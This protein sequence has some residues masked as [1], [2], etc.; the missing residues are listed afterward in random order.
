MTT[1]AEQDYA[2]AV[3]NPLQTRQEFIDAYTSG[4][5]LFHESLNERGRYAIPCRCGM[6]GC[7]GWQFVHPD[8]MERWLTRLFTFVKEYPYVPW[9]DIVTQ[10]L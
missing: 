2:Q 6:R 3:G 10:T 4:E 7:R 9:A 5:W 1:K 8:E